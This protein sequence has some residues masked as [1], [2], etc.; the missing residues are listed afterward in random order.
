MSIKYLD[1]LAYI[2]LTITMIQAVTRRYSGCNAFYSISDFR[3][4]SEVSNFEK[5]FGSEKS[6]TFQ[7]S[8][9]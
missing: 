2:V 1:R 3:R 7:L 6:V 4:I 8:T 9:A 5:I